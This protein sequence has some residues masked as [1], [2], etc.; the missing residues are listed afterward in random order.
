[1]MF[2]MEKRERYVKIWPEML[3]M[4]DFDW[5]LGG[6]LDTGRRP[7]DDRLA[8]IETEVMVSI[9]G[10]STMVEVKNHMV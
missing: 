3:K 2:F 6:Y 9:I 1:M 4:N 10:E 5:I 7:G 8:R